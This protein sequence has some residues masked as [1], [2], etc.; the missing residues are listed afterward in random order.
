[1]E[2]V[3]AVENLSKRYKDV[4]AVDGL[5]LE[6]K[7]GEIYGFI[8]LNGSGKTTTIRMMLGM[9][10]PTEGSCSLFG[11]KVSL[12]NYKLWEKV[13]YLVE[14]PYAYPELTVEEN[15]ELFRR[16]RQIKDSGAVGRIIDE[17]KLTPYTK[18]KAK[19]LSLGNAQRLGIAKA[20]LHGP[21]ILI[22][23]EPVNGLDP[24]GIVEVRELL[25]DLAKNKSV[26]IFLSS[27]LLSE[28]A[29]IADKIGIIHHGRLV[30]EFRTD[31]LNSLIER[32]LLVDTRNN[33]GAA[34]ALLEIKIACRV[35]EDGLIEIED[36]EL[37]E[38]PEIVS[39]KLSEMGFPPTYLNVEVE[40]LESYFMR[41]IR[42][43]GG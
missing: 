39:G 37:L 25:R 21:E 14:T 22:L 15:L 16:L 1:M 43:E 12:A 30:E 2:T 10:K 11:K 5:S 29:L 24:A 31:Q 33:E 3:I 26:S 42:G 35:N 23:D 20:M 4:L 41:S 27:H 8:G 18:R 7:K 13:G 36:N 34:E 9:I 40:S 28:V 32:K 38:R 19:H 17:L 6:L